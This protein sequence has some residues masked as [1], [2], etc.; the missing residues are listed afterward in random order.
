MPLL[1][2]GR[3]FQGSR[4]FRVQIFVCK[5]KEMSMTQLNIWESR[6]FFIV[7]LL[8]GAMAIFSSNF[9]AQCFEAFHV[10]TSHTHVISTPPHCCG[11][12]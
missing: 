2:G 12:P 6:G 11:F 4:Y 10:A 9:F 3:Y 5:R 7:L 8:H 1:S